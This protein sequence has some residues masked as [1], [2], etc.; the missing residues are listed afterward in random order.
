MPQLIDNMKNTVLN[1]FYR[2]TKNNRFTS[3]I[4]RKRYAPY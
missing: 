4:Y 3:D 1:K 2:K